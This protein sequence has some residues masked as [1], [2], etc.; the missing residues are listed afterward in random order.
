MTLTTKRVSS[1][2]LAVLV[3]AGV[4]NGAACAQQSPALPSATQT[5]MAAPTADQTAILPGALSRLQ[6][7]PVAEVRIAGMA[8]EHPGWLEPLLA[9]K[10]NA[11]LDKYKVRQSVQALYNTGQFSEIQVEAQRNDVGGVILSFVTKPNFFFGSIRV[12]GAP[13]TPSDNQLVNA[14]KLSLGDSFSEDKINAAIQGMQR[15][16]Q[17]NGYYRATIQPFYDWNSKDQQVKIV[18]AVTKGPRAHVGQVIITGIPGYNTEEILETAKIHPG[19]I[20]SASRVTRALSR[21]R[22]KY[23]KKNRLEAQVTLTRRD[24]RPQT[25]TL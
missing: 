8:T 5:Q 7:L 11:P 21:L 22:K 2:F 3:C 18:F 24:Y 23:Q 1:A 9:Q 10:V 17:E 14:G 12:E 16:L 15:L 6:G 25:N 19:D 20:V 4:C 13:E